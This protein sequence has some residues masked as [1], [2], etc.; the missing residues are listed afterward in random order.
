MEFGYWG[1]KALAE[2]S[3]WLIAYFKLDCTQWM[4]NEDDEW[5]G[6][7][8]EKLGLD[9]PNLPYLIDGDFKLTESTAIPGYLASKAGREDFNGEGIQEKCKLRMLEGVF[10]DFRSQLSDFY[11]S[12]T[13]HK[14]NWE[15]F[16]AA[17]SDGHYFLEKFS[18]FL[19]TKDYFL[20]HPTTFDI[21]F[22]YYV[23]M[24][25]RISA[26]LGTETQGFANLAA[27]SL[28]VRELPGIKEWIE[29][30]KHIPFM[31]PGYLKFE[32]L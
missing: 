5:F 6:S 4:C 20:G 32:I 31:S 16:I 3:R 19:G 2:P 1:I 9:F 25:E 23:W 26:S 18:K 27:H 28:R 11:Y 21:S 29:A 13:E 24:M 14:A 22:A 15:K 30:N 7:K 8:N 10:A 17:G 12:E